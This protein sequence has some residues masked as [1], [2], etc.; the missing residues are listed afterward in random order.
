MSLSF[1]SIVPYFIVSTVVVLIA[2]V[3]AK[4]IPFY[5]NL[6][7]EE[8]KGRYEVLDGLRG[9]L[10]LGV[11]FQHAVTNHAFF[12]TG[13]WQITD[14]RFYRHLGGE[15]VIMFFMITSF[16]Y[17]SRAIKS[18]GN[19]DVNKLYR[20]RF[21]RLGPMYV[22]SAAVIVLIALIQTNFIIQSP[23]DLLGDLLSWLTLGFLTTVSTNGIS[24]IP[25]NAGIH[26][27]L[28][29]EWIFYLLLPFAAVTL[30]RKSMYFLAI[31]LLSIIYFAP[32]RGYWMIF[33]FG[34]IAA[35]IVDKVPK[36]NFVKKYW[37][38]IVPIVGFIGVYHYQHEPYSFVQYCITLIILLSFIYGNDLFG[39]L[40]T[41][42]AIF[43]STLSYSIY[44][45][46]GIVLFVV[47]NI[48]NYFIKIS[49][50]SPAFFWLLVLFSA[51]LVVLVSMFTYRYIEHPFLIRIKE[52]R[53]EKPELKLTERVM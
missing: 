53:E 32:N 16:L 2:T 27:T 1:Y 31:P 40:R 39:L 26:W 48:T 11:L 20:S 44:L 47:L 6:V 8:S 23:F 45:L 4:K 41:K 18:K 30:R 14:V 24:I 25:I 34:I 13:I 51:I 43:L 36:L 5:K 9:F 46:H 28:H 22:F 49:V 19:V 42:A 12:T 29:F 10:A 3:F 50:I 7:N 15:A 17:W 33:L 21:F 37:F 52:K 35:H 38:S